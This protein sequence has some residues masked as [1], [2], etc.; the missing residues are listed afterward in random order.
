MA[1]LQDFPNELFLEIL[2]LCHPRDLLALITASPSIFRVFQR[3][4]PTIL[5]RLTT[6]LSVIPRP[7]E[8][9]SVAYLRIL[10]QNC[11]GTQEYKRCSK[12]RMHELAPKLEAHFI[13]DWPSDL[14]TLAA[15]T[16]ICAEVDLFAEH[17]RK[18]HWGFMTARANDPIEDPTYRALPVPT[19]MGIEENWCVRSGLISYELVCRLF[20]HGDGFL[21]PKGP[22]HSDPFE[23]TRAEDYS[24]S[25]ESEFHL[26]RAANFMPAVQ[27]VCRIHQKGLLDLL[28][29]TSP[30]QNSLL[31]NTLLP[32]LRR[33]CSE[34]KSAFL[35]YL[36]SFGLQ[37]AQEVRLC[38]TA[39][40]RDMILF[41]YS[42]FRR[43]LHK[44]VA[45]PWIERNSRITFPQPT[46]YKHSG[47]DSWLSFDGDDWFGAKWN[48]SVRSHPV[49]GPDRPWSMG[50]W[51]Q[52][53]GHGGPSKTDWWENVRRWEKDRYLTRDYAEWMRYHGLLARQELK[54]GTKETSPLTGWY[55][56]RYVDS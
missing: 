14:P 38:S 13:T 40:R 10:G 8:T 12:R 26:A 32:N 39:E 56:A 49:Y 2:C 28:R 19:E 24:P 6:S 52:K 31:P 34:E 48:R 47:D 22:F 45:R 51:F 11:Q 55:Y 18:A 1:I 54:P 4:R 36:T 50:P 41:K 30:P 7:T 5:K 29:C 35:R 44:M 3:Y 16:D 37:F 33:S 27:F 20:Y 46:S 53:Q 21:Y 43:T 9:L 25:F 17:I 23:F 42:S 15:L